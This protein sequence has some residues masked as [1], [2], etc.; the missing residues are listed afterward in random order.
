MVRSITLGVHL[1]LDHYPVVAARRGKRSRPPTR[2]RTCW[3]SRPTLKK[4]EARKKFIILDVRS[5]A[6]YVEGHVPGAVWVDH[7][8]W[9]K[10]FAKGQSR[11][12]WVKRIGGLR[13]RH[14]LDRRDLRRGPGKGRGPHLVDFALLGRQGRPTAQ[15]RLGRLTSPPEVTRPPTC[16]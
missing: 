8:E 9:D 10:A 16:S 6:D 15:R 11:D 7:G 2:S 5:K 4:A 14:L 1:M 13:H 12:E 3:S